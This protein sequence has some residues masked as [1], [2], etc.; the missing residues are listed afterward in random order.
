MRLF[1]VFSLA[2]AI[3]VL[4]CSAMAQVGGPSHDTF[5]AQDL[6]LACTA[7]NADGKSADGFSFDAFCNAYIRGLTDGLFL[8]KAF[9]DGGKGKCLPADTPIPN[10]E[11]R[12]DFIAF[13]SAHPEALKNS[14]GVVATAA[15]IAAHPCQ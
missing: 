8:R 1:E 13:V 6:Y 15:I 10:G 7:P 12:A 11:A 3:S 5:K 2:S 9:A 4:S 14:A